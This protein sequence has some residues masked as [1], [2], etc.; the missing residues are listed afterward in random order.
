MML[1]EVVDDSCTRYCLAYV[2]AGRLVSSCGQKVEK[3][4][5]SLS[6]G[7]QVVAS[8]THEA[9]VY[10]LKLPALNAALAFKGIDVPH[11]VKKQALVDLL[12]S[13]LMLPSGTNA[14]CVLAA[15]PLPDC[16]VLPSAP[17]LDV[18]G[19]DADESEDSD[20]DS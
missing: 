10:K 4:A 9:Q 11:G 20:L 16:A 5:A 6:L 8:L 12:K 13:T 14:P 19:S 3:R 15:D 18:S 2:Y 17:D 1:P 7:S